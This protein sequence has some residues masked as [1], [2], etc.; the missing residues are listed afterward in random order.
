MQFKVLLR[1]ISFALAT[2]LT[3]AAH[4]GTITNG[5]FSSCDYSGWGKDTDGA[6]DI[7]LG[8]DFEIDAQGSNCRVAI[9][10]D[11]FDPAGDPF[12][13][14]ISEAWFA[15]TLYQELDLAGN[16]DSTW[17][18]TIEFEVRSEE[19]SQDPLFVSDYFLFGLNDGLGNYYDQAGALGFLVD[20][21][22]IDGS[23]TDSLTF[24]LDNSFTNMSGWFLDAQLNVGVDLFGMPDGFGSTLY[25]NEVTL[26]EVKTPAIDVPEPSTL[27]LFALGLL[28]L[29]RRRK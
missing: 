21:T 25:I 6:G 7:S 5:G 16:A 9:N 4:A 28:G 15:N 1:T 29:G 12:G 2:L 17:A 23:F 13:T 27:A 26:V 24:E 20:P 14:P 10:V 3:I 18:L 22:D 8:N 11:Y 19:T